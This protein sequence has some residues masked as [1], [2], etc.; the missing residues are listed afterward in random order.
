MKET[1]NKLIINSSEK[2]IQKKLEIENRCRE[3][4]YQKRSI[5]LCGTQL[6]ER[7][8]KR[9]LSGMPIYIHDNVDYNVESQS[10]KYSKY[11]KFE[12]YNEKRH[13]Q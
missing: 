11:S 3:Q 5:S 7:R 4:F 8:Q 12:S 9:I 1:K 2:E 13:L 10:S 6:K